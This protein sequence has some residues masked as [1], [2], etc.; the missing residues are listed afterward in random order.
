MESRPHNPRI[1]LRFTKPLPRRGAL[2][3]MTSAEEPMK[4]LDPD[5]DD[6]CSMQPRDA[7]AR[8][9]VDD[10]R[11]RWPPSAAPGLAA[12]LSGGRYVP[13]RFARHALERVR[14]QQGRALPDGRAH[15]AFGP[16]RPRRGRRA[17]NNEVRL[18]DVQE[19]PLWDWMIGS[20]LTHDEIAMVQGAM[21]WSGGW[22]NLRD[23]KRSSPSRAVRCAADWRS[24][25]AHFATA[26]RS[27]SR[28]PPASC[29]TAAS[30]SRRSR[31]P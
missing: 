7:G 10:R 29:R 26:R 16:R 8:D 9:A 17:E 14:R 3:V 18:A 12:R 23:G 5:D 2:R 27:R 28:W 11:A 22:Q 20:G 13:H 24:P 19:G 21:E 30:P 31:A 25:N 6:S 1:A 4:D 15:L